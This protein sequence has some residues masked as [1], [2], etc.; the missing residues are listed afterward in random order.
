MGAA[1]GSLACI[2]NVLA[3]STKYSNFDC[4][5]DGYGINMRPL[6]VFALETYADDPC[7]CF[8]P[9]NP[10]MVYISQHDENFWAKVHKAISVIQF[11][12][13]GQII[14]RHP[15]FNMDNHLMLDKINYENGT[16]MLEGKEYKL[17]DTNFPTIN[18]ENPFELTDAEKELMNLLRSSFLRSEKLQN[19]VKFLYEKGS[20]YL[21]FNNNLLYHGCIPMNSDGTFTEVTLFGETVSGKS[22]MDK[23]EQLAR[24]GYFAKNG[25]EEK[26]YGKDFLWFLWCGCYSPVYGKNK[27]TSFER[28]FIDDESTWVEIKDEYYHLI[29]KPSVCNKILCEFGIDPNNFSHIING[30]VPVKIKKGESPIKAN[31]KLLV[32]DGGLSKAYQKVTGLAGYTLLFNSHG[33]LLSAHDAF[34]SIESAIKEEKD[35][36]STLDVVELAPNRLLVEDTDAGKSLSKKITDLKALVDAYLKGK[37]K[38]H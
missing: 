10:N 2:A 8:I 12:L 5:E 30:H 16:I 36:H 31:G 25:S 26:E 14:K 28:Y 11:K 6:T 19:H 33:L 23:A 13:E 21:T 29:E 38:T 37:I 22:L 34:E 3:I 1:A 32:I 18:P 17:K 4:L 24:D 27:M 7:E 15:E 20:I 9:R 35:I